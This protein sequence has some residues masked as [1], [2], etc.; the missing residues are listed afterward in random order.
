MVLEVSKAVRAAT[1]LPGGEEFLVWRMVKSFCSGS[2][3]LVRS[4]RAEILAK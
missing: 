2:S 3:P 4:V 1:V